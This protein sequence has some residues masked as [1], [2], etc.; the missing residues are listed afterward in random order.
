MK[1]SLKLM[2]IFILIVFLFGNKACKKSTTE[3]SA[4]IYSTEAYIAG[5]NLFR[6]QCDRCHLSDLKDNL[7]KALISELDKPDINPIEVL[8]N[9]FDNPK[10]NEIELTAEEL[11]EDQLNQ[12]LLFIKHPLE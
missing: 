4:T 7:F 5:Q 8:T 11:T 6:D 12:L 10:H 2:G 9:A 3:K 1:R